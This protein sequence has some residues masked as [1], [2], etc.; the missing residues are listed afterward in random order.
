MGILAIILFLLIFAL[1]LK[2]YPV[3]LTLGGA[4]TLFAIIICLFFPDVMKF[5]DFYLLPSRFMG[6]INNT[7]LIAVPLFIYMGIMLEKSGLAE[8]LLETMSI[9]F[10]KMN[11]GLAISVVI[12][13]S[14]L[15]ASTGIVGATVVTMGVISLPVMLKKG[16]KP[17][18]ATGVIA[19][20]GTL[21]QI[22]PPSVVL[23]LLADQ[24]GA[25]SRGVAQVDVGTIFKA[26][27]IPGLFLVIGYIIYIL[28]I[29]KMKPH[30]APAISHEEINALRGKGYAK[31]VFKAFFL[32]MLLIVAVLG[33]ILLGIASPTEAAAVG[34]MGATLLTLLEKKLNL[35]I[36]NSV[37][38]QTMQLTSMVFLILLGAT[39]FT[40]V[41]R[42]L[43][44]DDYLI[45]LI[46]Q[47]DLS[48]MTFLA[49]VMIVIFICGFFIDFI[50]IIFIFIPVITP[51]FNI[52]EVD[53]LW[54]AVLLALNLQT[55]FLTPPF[56]FS[57]FYLKGVAPQGITTQHLY[58]GIVP[59]III[60]VILIC[61]IILF[62]NLIYLI[63]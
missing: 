22:I 61:M 10:G 49:L 21:G 13:G 33:S 44:G 46:Q 11:G 17:E 6:T 55:S 51:I 31:R 59:F 62:P 16:Y 58:K 4:S 53:M 60:Q 40:L 14:L 37:M 2:G 23:I 27:I 38:R 43:G 26:A 39:T 19:S 28:V 5:Q 54:V 8:N 48:A 63:H 47:A 50:E 36:L 57:L 18:L 41:F 30:W 9:L 7:M 42:S 34:A 1:I 45:H 35:K 29:S 56:G 12:V 32:P 3:A 52:Y 25:N 24:I 15:A 20:S